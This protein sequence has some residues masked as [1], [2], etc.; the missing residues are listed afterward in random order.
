M[1]ATQHLLDAGRIKLRRPHASAGVRE[2][3]AIAIGLVLRDG[4]P[5]AICAVRAARGPALRNARRLCAA[6]LGVQRH[7][8]VVHEVD[9]L[10]DVDLAANGPV[11]ALG[12]KR[13]PYL[14]C[15]TQSEA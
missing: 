12:P 3:F 4:A 7:L 15:C 9:A 11:L 5:R 13:R 8:V 10:D 14:S 2:A 1:K 6:S